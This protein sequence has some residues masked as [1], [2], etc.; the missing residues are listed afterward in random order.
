MS[1]KSPTTERRLSPAQVLLFLVLVGLVAAVSVN[2]F[3]LNQRNQQ[4]RRGSRDR[5]L[6]RVR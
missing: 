6:R 3:L 1:S 2:F 4:G 5:K